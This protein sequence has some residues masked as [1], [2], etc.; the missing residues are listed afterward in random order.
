[1]SVSADTIE[2]KLKNELNASFVK[3]EDISGGCGSSYSV[4]IVSEKFEGKPLL[5]RHRLV[6]ACLEEELKSI[7]AFSQKTYTE[8]QWK[9]I[10][11]K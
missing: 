3:V 5:Q 10:N 11:A 6:N 4:I 7:H 9:K 8:E 1:M 2:N